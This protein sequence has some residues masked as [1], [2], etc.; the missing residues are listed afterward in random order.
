MHRA[1][2]FHPQ[3]FDLDRNEL[4]EERIIHKN[5]SL[6]LYLTLCSWE[7]M[8]LLLFPTCIQDPTLLDSKD[9]PSLTLYRL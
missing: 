4:F 1:Q 9:R 8:I 2:N 5:P 7:C 3:Y 6:T